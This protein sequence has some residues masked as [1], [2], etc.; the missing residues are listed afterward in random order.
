MTPDDLR[1]L[2][3]VGAEAEFGAG[4][5]LIE[6]GQHGS[7]LYV[8]LE[9]TVVV[10]APEGSRELGPGALIGERALLSG[11]GTRTAR[12]RTKSDVRVLAVDR[13]QIERLCAD[14]AAFASRLSD[15]S[16]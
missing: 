4:R 6:R 12:V 14:N 10:D 5:V 11:D 7:G 1:L 2:E 16:R 13:I 15:A 8:I 9:G 3:T